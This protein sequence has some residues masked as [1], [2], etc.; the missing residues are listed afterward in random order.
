MRRAVFVAEQG[1]AEEDE[2]DD[3]DAYSVHALALAAKRDAVGTGRLEPTGKI[4]RIAVLTEFRNRGLGGELL[5]W[6]VAQARRQGMKTVHLHAQVRALQFY[7]RHGFEPEGAEFDEVG[8]PH[9]RMHRQL[10]A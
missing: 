3:A 8:I 9:Q 10:I 7:L 6:L 4:G 2:W 1:I 5:E